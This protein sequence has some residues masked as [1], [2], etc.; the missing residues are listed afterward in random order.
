MSEARDV[1]SVLDAAEQAAAASDY[2]LAEQLLRDAAA[3]QEA[4]LGPLH[5]DLANTLNNLGIVC[6]ITEKP[7]DAE[8][9]FRRAFAIAT[10]A[11]QPDHP[12]VAT[13]RKNLEDFCEARGI[14]VD[15]PA[16]PPAVAPELNA[17]TTPSVDL[18][19][20]LSSKQDSRPA[21]YG[22]RLRPVA[23]VVLIAAALLLIGAVI[24]FGWYDGATS[25]ENPSPSEIGDSKPVDVPKETVSSNQSGP[26]DVGPVRG[27]T[28]SALPTTTKPRPSEESGPL[29]AEAHICRELSTSQPRSSSSEW[30]CV[31]PSVPVGPGS[32]FFYTRVKAPTNTTVEHRWYGGGHLFQAVELSIRANMT[33]GYRTYS[34]TTVNNQSPA[35]WRIEVRTR[36]GVL[37][38]EERF[39]IR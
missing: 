15:P 32:L 38:H 17:P 13:S 31:S 5:P 27:D 39:A 1:R 11:L 12:F 29:V 8:H 26:V 20:E 3:L 23:I 36:E 22:K 7:A 2:T 34:R 6:E 21:G 25:L 4:S 14:V 37:L 9:Y 24:W 10:A 33:G 19:P 16:P 30:K 35:E 18:L 28:A